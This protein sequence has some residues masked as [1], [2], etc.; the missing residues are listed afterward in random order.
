VYLA[1]HGTVGSNQEFYYVP[2][3]ADPKKIAETCVPLKQ[4]KEFFDSSPSHCLLLWLDFCHSGGILARRVAGESEPNAEATIERTLRV[5]QGIG[6]VIMCACTADQRAYE[7]RSH[8]RFT[9]YLIDGLKG[10][11]SNSQGEVTANSLHDYVDSKMGSIQQRPMFFG[12]QTGRIVLMRSRNMLLDNETQQGQSDKR[13]N[14]SNALVSPQAAYDRTVEII[15]S[16]DK[17]AW[18]RLLNSAAQ[19]ANDSLANWVK[20]S[21]APQDNAELLEP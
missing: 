12:N 3:D 5:L 1:G 8:G 15:G 21:A 13:L 11:A 19:K 10:G 9:R 7:D 17:L 14:F 2:F 20:R 6:K 16:R 4:I 18:R